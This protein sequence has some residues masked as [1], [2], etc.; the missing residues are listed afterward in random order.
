MR[1][2]SI[3]A[4]IPIKALG[5]SYSDSTECRSGEGFNDSG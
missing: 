5:T 2:V 3:T 1:K 4:S